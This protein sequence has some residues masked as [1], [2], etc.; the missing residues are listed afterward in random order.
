MQVQLVTMVL[1]L[2]SATIPAEPA[3]EVKQF[4]A[5][6]D[7][8]SKEEVKAYMGR[9]P[10][11]QITPH[12][13]RYQGSWTNPATMEDFNTVDISFGMLTDS[14]KYGVVRYNWDNK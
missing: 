14:H 3:K 2:L 5:D 7:T 4:E 10:N 9:G 8:M 12:V 1:C 11:E 6:T 13:W